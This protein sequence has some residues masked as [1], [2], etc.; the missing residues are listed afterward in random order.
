MSIKQDLE[1]EYEQLK[2]A[3]K[4]ILEGA[5]EYSIGTRMLQRADLGD[6]NARI[7]EL[8]Q[9]LLRYGK[10]IRVRKVVFI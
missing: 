6:I 1:E 10:G 4:A 9:M 5:Q 3:R 2:K 7:R 8:Q